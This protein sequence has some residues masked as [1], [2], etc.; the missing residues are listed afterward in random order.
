M[1]RPLTSV[2]SGVKI[3][4]TLALT[5]LVCA[6]AFAIDVDPKIDRAVRELMPV[7]ADAKI[8]YDTLSVKLPAGL[9]GAFVT[10]ESASHICD[11]SFAAVL[12]SSG[13]VFVGNPWPIANE[14]GKSIEEK[15]KNFTWRNMHENM[16]ATVDRTRNAD[17]LFPATLNQATTSGKLPLAG[18]VDPEGQVFFFGRFRPRGEE[19]RAARLKV[20]DTFSANAPTKGAAKPAVTIVEFSDFQCPSCQR[21]S[22]Y[23]DPILAKHGEKVRYIRYD[24]PLS[25]HNWAFGAALAGRAIYRQK[26]ELFWEYKK[27]VYANQSN[28]SPFT[29]WDWARGFAKDNELDLAKYD[30]DLESA[31]LKTEILTGAGTAL[32]NDIR[33]TPSY[34]I[35]G[36][37]VD[38][39][40][41]GKAL[42][43]YVEKLLAK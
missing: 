14:E 13:A 12:A 33:A 10:I 19:P 18:F 25:G 35:N 41:E 38:P 16:T 26:P 37:L 15:L 42:V 31:D 28:F 2:P 23:V 40:E 17:G 8:K 32:T 29:F 5:L 36:A 24:L 4:S 6:P 21:A 39:G 9:T 20:F 30:A 43:E 1:S 11:S 27:Q 34:M 7:C 22:G 3:L